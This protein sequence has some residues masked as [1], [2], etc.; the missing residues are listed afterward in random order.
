MGRE[1]IKNITKMALLSLNDVHIRGYIMLSI[2]EPISEIST[3]Y[4]KS[5]NGQLQLAQRFPHSELEVDVLFGTD[6]L[7]QVFTPEK[8]IIE[9]NLTLLP[10]VYGFVLLGNSDNK[11]AP[12]Y[13]SVERTKK[14][15]LFSNI[16]SNRMLKNYFACE[17][18]LLGAYDPNTYSKGQ[19]HAIDYFKQTHEIVQIDANPKPIGGNNIESVYYNRWPK[20]I[21]KYEF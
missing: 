18:Y 15:V 19:Q 12:S 17:S 8:I 5:F 21:Q 14:M 10:T 1:L 20:M 16:C 4:H 3:N 6:I 13:K 7:Q 2:C 11:V 9:Y